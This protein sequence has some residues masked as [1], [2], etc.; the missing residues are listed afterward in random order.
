MV[1]RPS[2]LMT[3]REKHF[4]HII[5][6]RE[7]TPCEIWEGYMAAEIVPEHYSKR[8]VWIQPLPN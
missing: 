2:N 6:P 8:V 1:L 3:A 7:N 4:V 5:H